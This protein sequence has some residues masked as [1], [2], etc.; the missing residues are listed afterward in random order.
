[1][2]VGRV[3]ALSTGIRTR[4]AVALAESAA[5]VTLL[6]RGS[7]PTLLPAARFDELRGLAVPG[8]PV[9]GAAGRLWAAQ[10]AR[11]AGAIGAKWS[12]DVVDAQAAA[13]ATAGLG[14]RRAAALDRLAL[15]LELPADR[16][17]LKPNEL[18]WYRAWAAA[19]AGDTAAML[20]H[21]EALP[22][23]GYPA[24]VRLLLARAADL[25]DDAAQAARAVALLDGSAGAGPDA[26]ALRLALGAAAPPTVVPAMVAFA[27][28]VAAA[29]AG[30]DAADTAGADA[31]GADA[32]GADA[33]ALTAVAAAVAD[34]DRL[35]AL[36]PVPAP[37]L[38]ALDA[39]AAGRCGYSVDTA[40]EALST[41]PVVLL[42]ELIT[43]G[44]L[45]RIPAADQ[46]WPAKVGRYLRCR[47]QP[48]EVD[49]ATLHKV[50]FV[51]EL[52][53]RRYLAGDA[54]G[55][56]ALPDDPAV[57]HYRA[58]AAYRA[59]GRLDRAALRPPALR[60]LERLDSTL[61]AAASGAASA[62]AEVA[63]DPSC[64]PLLRDA[65]FRGAVRADPEVQATYPDFAAWLEAI[66]I[67]RLVFA[68][69]WEQARSRGRELAACCQSETIRDETQSMLA[70]AQ[71][72]LG[73]PAAALQV[74]DDAL[75]GHFTNGL[76][77]NAALV[78][79]ERGCLPALPYL[80]RVCRLTTDPRV[81]QGALGRAIALWGDDDDVSDYPEQLAELVRGGLA[82][83]QPDDE[84]HRS[85]LSLSATC[86]ASWLAAATL[87]AAGPQADAV[88]YYQARA[89]LV[90]AEPN[91]STVD[92]GTALVSMCR[93]LPRPDW[94]ERERTWLVE[95]LLDLVHCP[96]GEAAGL[97]PVIAVLLAGGVLE[98]AE[99]L[100]LAVQAG[101][102]AA[103]GT[104]AAGELRADVEQR[105]FFDPARTYLARR[106]EL[107]ADLA[108]SVGAELARCVTAGGIAMAEVAARGNDAFSAEWARLV[109]REQW[110]TQNRRAIIAR[111]RALLD[112]VDAHTTRCRR[113]LKALDGLPLTEAQ[114]EWRAAVSADIRSWSAE[115]SRLRSLL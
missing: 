47:L 11:T 107:P 99:Q 54:A 10:A 65:A 73:D 34:L 70:F 112:R 104:G 75:D 100:V 8:P 49:E 101:A 36:P 60:T 108:D 113:Y 94:V 20:G 43:A 46:P 91:G 16:L 6:A 5:G 85:L 110:D 2:R 53:R 109:E 3:V 1:L 67:Q 102:H 93:Q 35:T 23:A 40:V 57:P 26:Q 38:R 55:L 105:L 87:P 84:F 88:R 33:G 39:W 30:A 7:D 71:W 12:A 72:Q 98:L 37:A 106:S 114:R 22:A 14:A 9:I 58:L 15:R 77:V 89:R 111:E 62:P 59:D 48:A 69:Q 64:W 83:G 50:G 21:L 25:I 97:V 52:A 24:R 19:V 27:E 42:D 45:T 32:A 78:A 76:M 96:F 41:L 63:G 66:G 61:A 51:A 92:V 81:R 82:A 115:I 31:A 18:T 74:L 44:S 103:A 68:G 80:A 90:A 56:D 86:D 13:H 28:R 79:A 4:P 17:G 29:G 95:L